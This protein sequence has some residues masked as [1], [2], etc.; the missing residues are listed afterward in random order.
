MTA[1]LEQAK[2]K[3]RTT[4]RKSEGDVEEYI[5]RFGEEEG[6]RRF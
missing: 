4:V 6:L 5:A 2:W 3:C 1:T